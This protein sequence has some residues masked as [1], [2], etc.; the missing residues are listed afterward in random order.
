MDCLERLN[1]STASELVSQP[2]LQSTLT[3]QGQQLTLFAPSEDALSE[4]D[5]E[6]GN[7]LTTEVYSHLVGV[8]LWRSRLLGRSHRVPSLADGRFIHVTSV[9]VSLC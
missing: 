7:D 1:L 3:D 6:E 9:S 8:S 2:E 4:V 5:L